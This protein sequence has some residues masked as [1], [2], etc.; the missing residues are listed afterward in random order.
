MA[1]LLDTIQAQTGKKPASTRPALGQTQQ[2]SKLLQAKT[3]KA[4]LPTGGPR[5]SA[6]AERMAAREAELGGVKIGQQQQVQQEQQQQQQVDIQQK[7]QQQAKQ[8][9]QNRA[10]QKQQLNL[11]S[12]SI[13]DTYVR[14]GKTLKNREDLANMETVGFNIR[15]NNEKYRNQLQNEGRK[16]RLDDMSNFSYTLAK[17]SYGQALGQ[18]L[19][20]HAFNS[21]MALSDREFNEKL[22][23][24]GVSEM[25]MQAEGA[26][27][28][29]GARAKG[30]AISG[31]LGGALQYFGS[32]KSTTEDIPVTVDSVFEEELL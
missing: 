16:S 14:G 19:D 13:L 8:F 18:D 12:Q 31:I 22:S 5:Q 4:Q 30:Q 2:I 10:K 29:A 26:Q 11:Q 27:A 20:R 3:G 21:L 32:L 28:R 7:T 9:E 24:Y 17:D 6:L 23:E 25:I 1:S 15:L